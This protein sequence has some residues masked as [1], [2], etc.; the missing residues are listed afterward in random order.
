MRARGPARTRA[1]PALFP[2]LYPAAAL[3]AAVVMAASCVSTVTRYYLPNA[4]NP[5]FDAEGATRMLDQYL[6]IQCPERL[7][8]KKPES[9]D[10]RVTVQADTSGAVTRAELTSTTGDDVLDDLFGTVA[11]QLKVDSL[12]ATATPLATRR[13]RLGFSCAPNTA[14]ATL[15][16]LPVTP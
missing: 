13:L 1:F 7:A 14:V 6:R 4:Q 5:R 15:E 10:V 9:G 12:R 2:A 11:A 16:L 8:A 3:A